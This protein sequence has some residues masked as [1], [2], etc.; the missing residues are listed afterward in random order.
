MDNVKFVTLCFITMQS[1]DC[2]M[3]H[4]KVRNCLLKGTLSFARDPETGA[5]VW[6]EFTNFFM[7]SLLSV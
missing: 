5:G 7:F 2:L 3:V 1:C 6:P 4:P